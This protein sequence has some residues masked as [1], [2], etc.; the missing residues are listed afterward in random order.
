M[1]YLVHLDTI[2]NYGTHY[3]ADP[4]HYWKFKGGTTLLVR[5]APERS[6][7]VI[8]VIN[9]TKAQT[10]SIHHHE[11]V[12]EWE[13]LGKLKEVPPHIEDDIA[14][15]YV[16]EIKWRTLERTANAMLHQTKPKEKHEQ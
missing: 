3:D 4:S 6:A 13:E 1:D 9:L 14:K 15:G 11:F 5:G 2:E 16:E 12:R 10:D 8:A 7:T